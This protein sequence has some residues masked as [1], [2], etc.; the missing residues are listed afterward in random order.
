ME[1]EA[2][3]KGNGATIF[4]SV[5]I[6][7]IVIVIIFLLS[8]LGRRMFSVNQQT[9]ANNIASLVTTPP[10]P[11]PTGMTTVTA[12]TIINAQVQAMIQN[13]TAMRLAKN[14]ATLTGMPLEQVLVNEGYAQAHGFGWI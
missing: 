5:V 14:Y 13:Q 4:W 1:G 9:I 6:T 11:L 12:T 3:K 10:N 7:L 8:R 2:T